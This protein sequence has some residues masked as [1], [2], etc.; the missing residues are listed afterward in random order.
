MLC[1]VCIILLPFL[2][3]KIQNAAQRP[4]RVFIESRQ[5]KICCTCFELTQALLRVM[6]MIANL[7]SPVM[8]DSARESAEPLLA[9]LFMVRI[10][11]SRL[12]GILGNF[13]SDSTCF[14]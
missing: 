13:N 8:L 10:F 5:L 12:K 2:Y 11:M 7:A 3:I 4:E 9:R 14:N 6:E 1:N